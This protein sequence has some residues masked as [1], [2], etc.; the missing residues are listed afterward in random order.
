MHQHPGK[1]DVGGAG[2]ESGA[3]AGAAGAGAAPEQLIPPFLS[4]QSSGM[5][6]RRPPP[7]PP[8]EEQVTTLMALGFERPAVLEALRLADN[9]SEAAANRLLGAM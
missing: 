3:G 4:A 9:N 6:Q 8:S 2:Q 5:F 7:P 1:S